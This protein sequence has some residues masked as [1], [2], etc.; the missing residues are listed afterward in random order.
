MT[1]LFTSLEQLDIKLLSPSLFTVKVQPIR[2]QKG[3]DFPVGP[4]SLRRDTLDP[5]EETNSDGYSVA[6]AGFLD[7]RHVEYTEFTRFFRDGNSSES[8]TTYSR[9]SVWMMVDF[10]G[11][12]VYPGTPTTGDRIEASS[13]ADTG[14]SSSAEPAASSPWPIQFRHPDFG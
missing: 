9:S 11:T 1:L 4:P 5:E 10:S 7:F 8:T 14:H 3:R 2:K 6:T 13:K 12:S